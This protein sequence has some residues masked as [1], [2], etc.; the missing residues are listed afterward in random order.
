MRPVKVT[1]LRQLLLG[2]LA[3]KP[4]RLQLFAEQNLCA[5]HAIGSS[6]YRFFS[7]APLVYSLVGCI[8]ASNLKMTIPDRYYV[9]CCTW[10]DGI[11]SCGHD[12]PTVR[13]AMGCLMP[14]GGGFIRAH[15]A[16]VFRSLDNRELIDFLESL[17]GMSWSS[18]NKAQG[19]VSAIP[20]VVDA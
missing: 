12:H 1:H 18:R 2:E 3:V 16:G 5:G 19:G 15:D 20:A 14:N 8:M 6:A 11:Y 17:E 4:Q 13:D 9:A 10:D 7:T